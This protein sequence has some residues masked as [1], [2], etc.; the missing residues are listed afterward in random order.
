M[1]NNA[2]GHNNNL[3]VHLKTHEKQSRPYFLFYLRLRECIINGCDVG[4]IIITIIIRIF[5]RIIM[6]YVGWK[7]KVKKNTMWRDTFRVLF[8]YSLA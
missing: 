1:N 8:I 4:I 7:P 3:Y 2:P 5:Y 6:K